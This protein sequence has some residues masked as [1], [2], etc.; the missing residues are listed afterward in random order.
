MKVNAFLGSYPYTFGVAF[1]PSHFL[2]EVLVLNPGLRGSMVETPPEKK[3][4]KT[5]K[6]NEKMSEE[7]S[8]YESRTKLLTILVEKP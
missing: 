8:Q 1:P 4:Q 6:K 7:E 2:C 3:G 5:C